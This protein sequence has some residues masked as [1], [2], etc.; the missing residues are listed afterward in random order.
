MP[1]SDPPK[2]A[3][4]VPAPV[5]YVETK[6]LLKAG[7][8]ELVVFSWKVGGSSARRTAGNAAAVEMR[9]DVRTAMNFMVSKVI[10]YI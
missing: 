3:A 2:T 7:F 9:R 1:T 8:G 4:L 10:Q 5:W 6:R